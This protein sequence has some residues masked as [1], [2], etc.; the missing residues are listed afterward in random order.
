MREV[1]PRN[2]KQEFRNP[3]V[4]A[5]AVDLAEKYVEKGH[6]SL[7]TENESEKVSVTS[8]NVKSE[9]RNSKW[10]TSKKIKSNETLQTKSNDVR[11]PW[12][13]LSKGGLAKRHEKAVGRS[14][15]GGNR[16]R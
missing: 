1:V 6:E 4:F 10:L 11:L 8:I 3:A 5:P 15:Y 7:R 12:E 2:P 14:Q 9:A 13:G 16:S